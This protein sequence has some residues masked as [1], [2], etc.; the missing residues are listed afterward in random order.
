MSLEKNTHL[1]AST[2][3]YLVMT[4]M[5][6]LDDDA[7][8]NGTWHTEKVG[9][10][11]TSEKVN[12][13]IRESLPKKIK[14]RKATGV[15]LSKARASLENTGHLV[16]GHGSLNWATAY[17]TEKGYKTYRPKGTWS[18]T[19]FRIPELR[20]NPNEIGQAY[21]DYI[22]N[23]LTNISALEGRVANFDK[24]LM[25]NT[26]NLPVFAEQV[27]AGKSGPLQRDRR[28]DVMVSPSAELDAP[29]ALQL[30]TG[31]HV[32]E[33]WI[34]QV[35]NQCIPAGKGGLGLNTVILVDGPA[36]PQTTAKAYRDQFSKLSKHYPH[37]KGMYTT[38]EFHEILSTTGWS[39]FN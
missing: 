35:L 21:E 15:T 10:T 4:T 33:P 39:A 3:R 37:F 19:K 26:S 8:S 13:L 18:Y 11:W 30:K 7:R 14:E 27:W 6:K 31:H 22:S 5:I 34:D 12:S 38:Q 20:N 24:R 1:S 28:V 32:E 16:R 25:N 29:L 17:V 2:A 36:Y 9:E 23:M